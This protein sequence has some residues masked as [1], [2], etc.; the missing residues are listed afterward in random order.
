MLRKIILTQVFIVLGILNGD[1]QNSSCNTEYRRVY[2][3]YKKGQ[4]ETV[5]NSFKICMIEF[6]QNKQQYQRS[7]GMEVVFRVYKLIIT[8]YHQIDQENQS[9][10]KRMQLTQ[11]FGGVLSPTEVDRQYADTSLEP[12]IVRY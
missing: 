6:T 1:A 11:Y 8:S 4:F 3:L 2:N 10:D 9:R 7:P 5:T 12:P